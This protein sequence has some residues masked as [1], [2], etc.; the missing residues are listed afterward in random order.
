[1][2]IRVPGAPADY[3]GQTGERASLNVFGSPARTK[4]SQYAMSSAAN[5]WSAGLCG[6]NTVEPFV[7]VDVP[8]N[9]IQFS[10]ACVVAFVCAV[11]TGWL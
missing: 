3:A 9:I 2:R 8:R 1:M 5:A 4:E 11:G 6:W 7:P 10:A